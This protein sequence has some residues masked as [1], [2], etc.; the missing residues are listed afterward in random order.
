MR[1]LA[2]ENMAA[3]A[4]HFAP[5]GELITAPGR[6]IDSET[7]KGVDVLLVRSVTRVD[8]AL[9]AG[10][11]VRF[12]GS[13]TIGTDHIDLD[14]LRRQGIAFA[15]APGCNA[16][17]VVDYMIA[18]FC[19]CEPDWLI[20]TVAIVGCG[21]VGGRLYRRLRALGVDCL[22][23][24]PW[25]DRDRIP[26]LVPLEQALTADI[27]C[28]HT[29]L[30]G[31]GPH[32][33]RHLFDRH[34]LAALRPEALLV[35]AGRGAVVD[36]TALRDLLD[37]GQPLRPVLDVWENEPAIDTR[38][39]AQVALA[40]PHIAGYSR[41]GKLAG[42]RMVQEAFCRWLGRPVPTQPVSGQRRRLRLEQGDGLAEAVLVAYDPRADHRRMI[43]AM[44][45]APP[46]RVF[47]H[48]R[49]HYPERREFS[50]FEVTG[51]LAPTLRRQL[52][53]LG[54]IVGTHS[55]GE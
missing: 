11:G 16:N 51:P 55:V 10:S 3:V 2:D 14:Y 6:D 22:C 49:R 38:L 43:E 52:A 15:S 29:P 8:E 46:E 32:P 23:V 47:D 24:D 54:F 25:L 20:K 17:A 41:E 12:V 48:L 39:L 19:A 1:I 5:F 26:D 50:Q 7:L 18:V 36:N 45:S 35:N 21:N 27:L 30:V 37:A 28:L 40:T 13:A 33:T 42:T 31:Q 34:R 44:A 9:L 53:A 4:E